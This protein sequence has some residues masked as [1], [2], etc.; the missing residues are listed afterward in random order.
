L[1]YYTKLIEARARLSKTIGFTMRNSSRLARG[2][3]KQLV[4]RFKTHRGSLEAFNNHD[5]YHT[6]LIAARSRLSRTVC[7]I[8]KT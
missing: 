1:F 3:Q 7:F 2:F 5:F 8:M 4:L 6:K